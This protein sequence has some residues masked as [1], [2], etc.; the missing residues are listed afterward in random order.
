MRRLGNGAHGPDASAVESLAPTVPQ[1]PKRGQASAACR[2]VLNGSVADRRLLARRSEAIWPM[3]NLMMTASSVGQEMAL[4]CGGSGRWLISKATS[5]GTRR[6]WAA[7]ITGRKAMSV[8]A[9]RPSSRALRCGAEPSAFDCS[10]KS[11]DRTFLSACQGNRGG[12][13][14]ASPMPVERVRDMQVRI[15]NLDQRLCPAQEVE[16]EPC[17][18]GRATRR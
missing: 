2:T 1:N 10:L 3:V 7:H 18:T 14:L 9:G 13:T 8:E 11:P 5:T 4:G 15:S 6:P 16:P 12:A 17:S